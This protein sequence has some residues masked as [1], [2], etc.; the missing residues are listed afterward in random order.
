[1]FKGWAKSANSTTV[2]YA[3]GAKY[4]ANESVTLYAVWQARYSSSADVE[5]YTVSY[6]TN[7]GSNVNAQIKTKGTVITLSTTIPTK[8]GYT[9]AGWGL[10]EDATTVSY[11]AGATYSTDA[12]VVLYAI[13]TPWTHTVKYNLNGGTGTVPSSFTKTTDINV[14]IEEGAISK[15]NCEFKC[16]CTNANGSGGK[17]Y[18][19]GDAYDAPKNGG[20]VTL[21]AI[22]RDKVILI[23][24]ETS[25]CKANE[26][27]ENV[28]TLGFRNDGTVH[29]MEIIESN[30]I[31]F[32]NSSFVF[33]EIIEK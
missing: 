18:Y 22:W 11:A 24:P 15:A 1:M 10:S 8:T 5:T 12:D 25:A 13:W 27:F 23:Y 33:S 9:F 7:G 2:S 30:A 19:V 21:Y 14:L 4:T 3:A 31:S 17:N 16:W 20:T 28:E 29:A 32:S 6:E 26:F